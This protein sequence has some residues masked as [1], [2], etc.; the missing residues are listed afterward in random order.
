MR[1]RLALGVF[2][3]LLFSGRDASA[4]IH[5][6]D[7]SGREVV[8]RRGAA[9][10]SVARAATKL[11]PRSASIVTVTAGPD[12]DAANN[13]YRRIQNALNA[14]TSGDT[15]ILSGTFDFTAP[16]AAAA[17]ALGNDNTAA[18]ADD[19][20]VLVPAVSNVTLTATALGSATIQGPGDLPAVNL[21]SFLVFDGSLSGATPGWTISNL[22]IPHMDTV[23]DALQRGDWLYNTAFVFMMN[24]QGSR[25]RRLS[26]KWLS[27]QLIRPRWQLNLIELAFVVMVV[28]PRKKNFSSILKKSSPVMI[29]R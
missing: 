2:F 20:E 3:L 19:Y 12:I 28:S 27:I 8:L 10:T 5:F 11:K 18:T 15:I 13:D 1:S 29:T 16:F 25:S 7:I 23:K 14:A 22:R 9:A 6:T 26:L 21:E 17:W 24:L 4:V